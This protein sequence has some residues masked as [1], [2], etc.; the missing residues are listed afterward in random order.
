MESL[1]N[2]FLHN[3]TLIPSVKLQSHQ[4]SVLVE[5]CALH[6]IGLP[7]SPTL[8]PPLISLTQ[9]HTTSHFTYHLNVCQTPFVRMLFQLHDICNSSWTVCP[10]QGFMQAFL[11]IE[12]R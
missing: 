11:Q 5:T 2:H 8:D 3:S 6:S 4:S 9:I 1:H 12:K 10:E 7:T